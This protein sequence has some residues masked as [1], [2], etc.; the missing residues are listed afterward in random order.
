MVQPQ[1][2]VHI[3][4]CHV[5]L[6]TV[7]MGIIVSHLLSPFTLSS[8]D[9]LRTSLHFLLTFLRCALCIKKTLWDV[10]VPLAPCRVLRV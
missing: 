6:T 5:L 1:P 9:F 8:L 7:D 4:I 3:S 10:L 2:H